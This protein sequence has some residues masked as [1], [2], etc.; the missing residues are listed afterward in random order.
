MLEVGGGSVGVGGGVDGVG[1]FPLTK[2]N[3]FVCVGDGWDLF[4]ICTV[5]STGARVCLLLTQQQTKRGNTKSVTISS[6][7]LRSE[8]HDWSGL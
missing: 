1:G 8:F 5:V 3:V 4:G 2:T 6:L 7:T